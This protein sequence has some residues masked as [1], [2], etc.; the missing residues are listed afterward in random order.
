MQMT[1]TLNQMW[2]ALIQNVIVGSLNIINTSY[3]ACLTSFWTGPQR[4]VNIAPG[5]P[6][7]LMLPFVE[8]YGKE[9]RK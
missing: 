6:F 4:V 2:I 7:R 9:T 5:S 8:K 1:L 3:S